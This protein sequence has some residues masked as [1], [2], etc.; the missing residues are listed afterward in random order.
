MIQVLLALD[1]L[2]NTLIGGWADE[3]LSAR[4]HRCQWPVRRAINV[5]FFW[6]TDH[7][8]EAYESEKLQRQ[9]PAEYRE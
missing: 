1:Q 8:L 4:A 3:S 9:L 6:Q 2:A 7:C 5:L